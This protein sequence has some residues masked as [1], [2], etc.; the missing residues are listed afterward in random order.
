MLSPKKCL[1]KRNYPSKTLLQI[2][3]T[4]LF[5]SQH[6]DLLN[7]QSRTK[8]LPKDLSFYSL[9]RINCM[10]TSFWKRYEKEREFVLWVLWMWEKLR[11][12]ERSYPYFFHVKKLVTS[13]Y[14]IHYNLKWERGSN[15]PHP[16][17]LETY[18]SF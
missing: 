6:M 1:R 15:S 2:L 5:S 9:V 18:F 3:A 8:M 10:E 12:R 14:K 16:A 13:I 11:E 17:M 7:N 4:I